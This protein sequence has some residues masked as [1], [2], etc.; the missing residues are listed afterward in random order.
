V[1]VCSTESDNVRN[2]T[3]ESPDIA[4]NMI[5]VGCKKMVAK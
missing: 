4:T 2:E 5:E 1:E 3:T